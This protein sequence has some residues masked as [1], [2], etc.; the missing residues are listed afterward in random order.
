MLR[1]LAIP[2]GDGM[3]T[4][5]CTERAGDA[6]APPFRRRAPHLSLRWELVAFAVTVWLAFVVSRLARFVL[7]EDVY[8]RVSLARGIPYTVSTLLHYVILL[9]GFIFAVAA[10]GVDL[11]R[12]TILVGAFGVGIGFGLQAVVNNVVSGFIL[13][14]ERFIQVGDAIQIGDL[15]GEVRR[16]GIR[17]SMV[18]TWE[19]AEVSCPRHP[20]R[21]SLQL[22]LSEPP[23]QVDRRVGADTGTRAQLIALRET[24]PRITACFARR[25]AGLLQDSSHRAGLRARVWTPASRRRAG[26]RASSGGHHGRAE[27][28]PVSR[29]LRAPRRT[30]THD[31]RSERAAGRDR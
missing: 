27:P 4:L 2:A 16:S 26:S 12:V 8:P 7:E 24:P 15:A 31:D 20:H 29:F 30:P 19:G 6:V 28:R 18:R 25:A 5:G 14:F 3:R 22:D 17:S 21:R 23:A 13:L 11:N 1:L 10:M 9:L